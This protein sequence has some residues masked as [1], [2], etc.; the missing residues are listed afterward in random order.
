MLYSN[1]TEISLVH[2]NTV[3]S[4]R[5]DCMRHEPKPRLVWRVRAVAVDLPVSPLEMERWVPDTLK[6][7]QQTFFR[8]FTSSTL[9]PL[10][11]SRRTTPSTKHKSPMGGET[12]SHFMPHFQ[13]SQASNLPCS[14]P[15][16]F[17]F[18]LTKAQAGPEGGL[19]VDTPFTM[20]RFKSEPFS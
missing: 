7:L 10:G 6:M 18:R 14:L 2:I 19:G 8:R 17:S 16:S 15:S 1:L 4:T 5:T 13:F 9:S 11:F 20:V 3:I 12:T